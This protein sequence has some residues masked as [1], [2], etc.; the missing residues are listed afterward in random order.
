MTLLRGAGR[1]R[2]TKGAE[3][4]LGSAGRSELAGG[5]T[6]DSGGALQGER[7]PDPP[8]LSCFQFV[9]P[10][11]FCSRGKGRGK[12]GVFR[13]NESGGLMPHI[14]KS[15]ESAQRV[16]RVA[17]FWL[18][19]SVNFSGTLLSCW[20]VGLSSVPFLPTP[21]PEAPSQSRCSPLLSLR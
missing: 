8:P 2:A 19:S 15:P 5:R 6:R 1:A 16:R 11:V 21:Q 17:R 3:S 4:Q 10:G 18:L 9:S 14:P 7:R 20:P 12:L 13:E